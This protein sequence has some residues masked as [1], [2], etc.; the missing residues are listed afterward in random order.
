MNRLIL[1]VTT[2]L[3]LSVAFHAEA[4][5]KS[6]I[7]FNQG[8]SAESIAP[9]KAPPSEPVPAWDVAFG[10][11]IATDYISRGYTQTE[12]NPAV[13]GYAEVA[14]FDWFYAG[15]WSSNVSFLDS[16]SA[17][18][19]LYAGLRH[20][21]DGLTLDVGVMGY[22]YPGS[23]NDTDLNYWEVYFKPSYAVNDWL[24]L[25]ATLYFTT[26]YGATGTNGTYLSGTAKV[27]LPNFGSSD[28]FGWFLSGELGRQWLDSSV[29]NAWLPID[30]ALEGYVPE[31]YVSLDGYNYWNAGVGFTFRAATLD[32]RYHGSDLSR[33]ECAVLDSY[34][35]CGDRYVA[36]LSFA[37][38]L[39]SLK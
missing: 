34:N 5:D 27:T 4:D 6:P 11:S 36:T 3:L 38:S 21:W 8:N 15:V 2:L 26:D 32:L 23:E 9:L 13:Q 25:G 14:L 37:T 20:T 30:P 16:G 22:T 1:G 24:T 39:N 28:E 17:E 12:G 7:V 19:D 35:A 29:Y 33:S 31:Y 10:I 18:V